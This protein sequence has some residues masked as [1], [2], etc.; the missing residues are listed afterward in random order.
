[1]RVVVYVEGPSDR[2]AMEA[3]LAGLI[4]K[5]RA[6]GVSI[7]FSAIGSRYGDCKSA[8]VTKIPRRAVDIL[9]N[10]SDTVAIVPDLYPRNK[11][12]PHETAEELIAGLNE[13]FRTALRD[14][15]VDDARMNERFRAFCFKHDLEALLL[16]CPALV[17][18]R[19]GAQ[20][21]NC[22][23][24]TPV[25]DQ[26]Q[27]KPP[28]V[29]VESLFRE[30]GRRYANT[31]DAPLIL[32]QARYQDVARCCPQWFKPFVEFLETCGSG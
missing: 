7:E 4:E 6:D 14:K 2:L 24:R 17:Q 12:F 25:E 9:R 10:T 27:D 21:L 22:S 29:V 18:S 26:N 3:L 15:G 23:W 16:A 31:V 28:K 5:R 13:A 32:A 8:L 11:G 19:L 30:H 1:M 20:K